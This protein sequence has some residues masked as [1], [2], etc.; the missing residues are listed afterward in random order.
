MATIIHFTPRADLDARAN[1]AGFVGVCRN[2]LTVFGADLPFDEDVW[3]VTEYINLKAKRCQVR[4]VFSSWDSTDRSAPRAMAEPFLSFAKGYIRYQH[5]LRPTKAFAGRV[6]ALRALEKA[7][8]EGGASPDPSGIQHDTLHRA[9]QLI[10]ARFTAAAA[11]RLARQLEMISD[12]L[13]DKRL[14]PL[15]VK[16]RNPLARPREDAGRIGK[17]FDERRQQKLP[18]PAALDALAKAFR[19]AVEPRDVVATSVAAILCSAPDRINEVL[20]LEADC[21]VTQASAKGQHVEYG[22]RWRPAKGADPMVKWIVRSMADVVKEAI[23]RIARISQAARELARWY[24]SNPVQIFLPS[25]LEYLRG[26]PWLTMDELADVLY[27]EGGSARSA[28]DW[29]RFKKI[30]ISGP[31]GTPKASFAKV[32]DAVLAI[33]PKGFPIADPELGLRYSDMLC[34]VRKNALRSDRATLRCALEALNH[35]QISD[36]LGGRAEHGTPSLFIRLGLVESDGSDI[37]IT[38]HQFRHFLNTLAQIGGL[39]QLDIA[40]WSGRRDV[41]QNDAYNHESNRDVVALVRKISGDEYKPVGPLARLKAITLIPR[42]EFARLKVPTAHTTEF[43]YCLHDFTMTPCQIHRD[44]MNCDE[45]V[46][47]K[48]D[49]IR[50]ANLRRQRLEARQLL[51]EAK[52]A[53]AD[54]YA[55][56][57]RWVEHQTRTLQR[58][59]RLCDILDDPSIPNGALIQPSGI[60]PAS[61]LEQ[62]SERRRL[63]ASDANAATPQLTVESRLPSK[64]STARKPGTKH[65]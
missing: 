41:S 49:H 58:M 34:V 33:L 2:K 30:E 62:A 38:S 56:A 39:S 63:P 51:M 54:G 10:K 18:S 35:Q 59:D 47:I 17:E 57:D 32:E 26:Q 7:L 11:Y 27:A 25:S 6:A 29:C 24:E 40:R 15:A 36:C 45:Q 64:G 12:F 1:L 53:A 48:G 9:A 52:A 65:G 5:S 44:C 28:R 19:M 61:R 31:R 22:L 20:L 37:R 14:M 60:V 55:G 23:A 21:E 8:S 4:I 13:I 50:E 42:D 16:W 3:T 46:C 43:G